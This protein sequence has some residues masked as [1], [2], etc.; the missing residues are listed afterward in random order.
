M[1][2]NKD[3][4]SKAGTCFENS[5]CAEMMQKLMGEKGIG[6]LC[7]EMMQK[8]REHGSGSSCEEMMR[9]LMKECRPGTKRQ[10]DSKKED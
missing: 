3:Q 8:M 10:P 6:S 7:E 5:P 4:Q 2:E 9:S 1:K